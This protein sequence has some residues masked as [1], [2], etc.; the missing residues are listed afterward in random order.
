MVRGHDY[1]RTGACLVQLLTVNQYLVTS[2]SRWRICSQEWVPLPSGK[3][4]PYWVKF[5]STPQPVC[6]YL[7]RKSVT[8]GAHFADISWSDTCF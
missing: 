2:R 8:Y 6:K 3:T 5:I 4:F 1:R 7:C